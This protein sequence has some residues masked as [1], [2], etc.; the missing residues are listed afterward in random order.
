[1]NKIID[2]E[3]IAN[4]HKEKLAKIKICLFD[5]DGILTDGRLFWASEEVGFNRFFHTHDGYGL[6]ILMQA[7]LKVG[8]ITGGDS[9]G[10]Q[11]RFEGLGVDFMYMGSED[12]R[13]AFEDILQKTNLKPEQALYMGDEFFDLPILK[14]AGFSATVPNASLEIRESV[15][16]VTAR[17]SGN[18]CVREVIDL[19]RFVQNIVPKI[20]Y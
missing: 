14:R 20:E 7:G 13:S 4:K 1:M 15:D 5:V 8:I 18:A 6:K 10:V 9:L 11:K 2:V 3:T 16:Y 19:L 12:K 17:E